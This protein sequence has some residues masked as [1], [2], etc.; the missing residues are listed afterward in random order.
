MRS[1]STA[2]WYAVFRYQYQRPEE[3]R[4]WYRVGCTCKASEHPLPICYHKAFIY[5]LLQEGE[6]GEVA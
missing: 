1:T 5:L 3:T 2:E 4:F 6:L